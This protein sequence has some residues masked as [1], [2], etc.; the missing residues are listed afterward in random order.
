MGEGGGA[1]RPQEC[2]ERFKEALEICELDD[3]GFVGDA[4]TWRNN[5][6]DANMYIR[7]RLDRAVATQKWRD[8]FPMFKVINGDP[9][10]SDHRPIIVDT[11]GSEKARRGPAWGMMPKFE[12]KWIEEEDYMSIVQNTWETEVNVNHKDVAGAVKGVLSGLVDWSKNV[13]G[14]LEKWISKLKKELET[15]RSVI[16]QEMGLQK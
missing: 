11:H 2:M 1:P 7:E 15:W 12:A 10:H 9:R 6:H 3:L 4:F 16:S 13:L 5:S 14:D 8:R